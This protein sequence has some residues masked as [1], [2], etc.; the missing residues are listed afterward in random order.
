MAS[1]VNDG[2]L[3]R[4]SIKVTISGVTYIFLNFDDEVPPRSEN[5]YDELGKPYA[6][7]HADDFRMITGVIRARSDQVAPPKFVTFAYDST[8]FY[9]K[10]R[11]YTGST[12]GLKEYA[13]TLQEQINA[14]LTTS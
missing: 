7:S 6:A 12:A 1:I 5:D 14:T 8:N 4:G 11:K 10:I 3:V 2:T 9:I 13:V